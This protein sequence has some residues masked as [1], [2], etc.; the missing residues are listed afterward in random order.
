MKQNRPNSRPAVKAHLGCIQQFRCVGDALIDRCPSLLNVPCEFI[1]VV[2]LQGRPPEEEPSVRTGSPAELPAA[3]GPH[4]ELRPPL[5]AEARARGAQG[6][7]TTSISRG[8]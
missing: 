7:L 6:E 5:P 3:D 1:G 4:G 2:R 8:K